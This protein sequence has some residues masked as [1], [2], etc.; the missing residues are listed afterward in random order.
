MY[1]NSMYCTVLYL[2]SLEYTGGVVDAQ[3]GPQVTDIREVRVTRPKHGYT[4]IRGVRVTR[5]KHGYTYVRE[6][7]VTRPKH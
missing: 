7:R 3:S 5:P 1:C 2:E 6:L 4:Y